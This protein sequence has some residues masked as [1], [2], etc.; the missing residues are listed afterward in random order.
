MLT[1]HYV[2]S[3]G[4]C[5][6]F[7]IFFHDG[8]RRDRRLSAVGVALV[9]KSERAG[10]GG[11]GLGATEAGWLLTGRATEKDVEPVGDALDVTCNAPILGEGAEVRSFESRDD[12]LEAACERSEC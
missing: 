10:F 6:I 11:G 1:M 9:R 4:F 3:R 7:R 12:R 8:Q 2:G 5:R